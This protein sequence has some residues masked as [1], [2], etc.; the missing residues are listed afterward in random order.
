VLKAVY[1]KHFLCLCALFVLGSAII[2]APAGNAD[3]FNFLVFLICGLLSVLAVCIFYF[4][5]INKVTALAAML[6]A[7]YCVGDAF[8]TFLK[9]T[10]ADLL[11]ETKPFLIALPIIVLLIY[12]VFKGKDVVLKFGF[13]SFFIVLVVVLLFFFSTLKDFNFR[14]IFI[15]EL[16][17]LKRVCLE[18]L[19]YLRTVVLPM[20]LLSLFA[21]EEGYKIS[22]TV[23]GVGIG[24]FLFAICILNS[25]LLFGI[26]FAG[27]L[28]YPYSAAGSTVTFGNLFTRM[29]GLLHFVYL[30]S[31]IVRC[32]VG[33][34]LIKKSRSVFAP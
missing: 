21:R 2:T 6:L 12:L 34:L 9:F 18:S 3:E 1:S 24:L 7:F 27:D 20:V 8:I 22:L 14:N 15:Y 19:P 13:I 5:P 29:D 26:E 25:V 17:S 16:P 23:T 11:P 28:P 32:T 33:T 30:S 4:V 10:K 31:C